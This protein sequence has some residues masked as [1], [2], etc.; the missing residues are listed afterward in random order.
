M[1]ANLPTLSIISPHE[2]RSERINRKQFEG[3]HEMLYGLA[4]TELRTTQI[5]LIDKELLPPPLLGFSA[6]CCGVLHNSR[7]CRGTATSHSIPWE[8]GAPNA[9]TI[10]SDR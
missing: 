10:A 7:P 5:I 9:V 4:Q 8:I 6:E 1:D 3:F 2:N